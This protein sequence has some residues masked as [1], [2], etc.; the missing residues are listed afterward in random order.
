MVR[1]TNLMNL[2]A[3][4]IVL[5]SFTNLLV[6]GS[7]FALVPVLGIFSMTILS[8]WL[9]SVHHTKL[10]FHNAGFSDNNKFNAYKPVSFMRGC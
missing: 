8:L 7:D 1:T 5:L 6:L 9:N 10:S 4:V 3:L 2:I